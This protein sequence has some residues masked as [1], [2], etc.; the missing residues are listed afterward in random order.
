MQINQR[1]SF[2][3]ISSLPCM[4]PCNE[5]TIH[6]TRPTLQLDLTQLQ[7]LVSSENSSDMVHENGLFLADKKYETEK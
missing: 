1:I 3:F 4:K 5:H 2:S 6:K 7:I